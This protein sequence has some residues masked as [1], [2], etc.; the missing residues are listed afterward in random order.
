M[1]THFAAAGA[2]RVYG[3]LVLQYSTISDNMASC[4]DGPALAGG[5]A[6]LGNVI[7]QNSTISGN[8]AALRAAFSFT[9]Y[10]NTSPTAVMINSTISGNTG[11]GYTSIPLTIYNSTIASNTAGLGVGGIYAYNAPLTL[12]STIIADNDGIDLFLGGT[13]TVSGANNL[14]HSAP[15]VP[16]DTIRDCPQ[17]GPLANNGGV[18]RTHMPRSTSPA[19][20]TGS[21]NMAVADDQRGGGFPRMFGAGVDIGAVE[22]QGGTDEEIFNSGFEPLCDH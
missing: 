20:D 14:I 11:Y 2:V 4:S 22:W 8:Q 17:L 7:I 9:P 19:I 15:A 16:P 13:A 6:S 3:D 10:S 18:T 1:A 21:N 5:V 12:Q